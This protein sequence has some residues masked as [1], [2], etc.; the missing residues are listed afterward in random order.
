MR[1]EAGLRIHP[2]FLLFVTLGVTAAAPAAAQTAASIPD[3]SGSWA[4][5]ALNGLELP[6]SGPG[7][8]RNKSREH[9]GPQAG[10]GD[11]RQ[12]VGDYT[13]PILQPWASEVVKKFGDISLAG[14]GFA[15]PRN[16]CWPEQV[17]FVF[18][19]YGMQV[20]QQPDKITILY[21]FDHQFRQIRLNQPHTAPV[22]PSW[23]GDSVGHY[24]GGTLVVDTVGI[25]VGPFSMVDWFG[26][27]FTEGLHVTER[28]RLLDY[29]ATK[30]AIDR[31]AKEHYQQADPDNGP[32][33]D[34]AYKGKGLQIEVTIEDKG[35][36]TMPWSATVTFRRALDERLELVCAENPEWFPGT[37]S[38]VPKADK[39]D[40]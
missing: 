5:A 39:P 7:P 26:T 8:V 16:Q 37:Y 11:R 4:H 22:A 40:F 1:R 12:L 34:P 30:A 31:D 25:K 28:Y 19:N 29:E 14:K 36:F 27:P 9:A 13:N 15:T 17:P 23:Y 33:F 21:P 2:D 32:A 6:L 10:V 3:L 20:L 35:A 18:A 24:E 38:A